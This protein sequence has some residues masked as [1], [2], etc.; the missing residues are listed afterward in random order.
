MWISKAISHSVVLDQE[1]QSFRYHRH[2][3]WEPT[4]QSRASAQ[5]EIVADFKVKLK[6][7][8]D[9]I[10]D[11]ARELGYVKA[12]A[13]RRRAHHEWLVRRLVLRETVSGLAKATDKDRQTIREATSRL[14]THLGLPDPGTP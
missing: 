14:A 8:L 9:R 4:V 11:R 13:R 1:L 3:P 12:P 10:E 2:W 5:D 6:E 7:H